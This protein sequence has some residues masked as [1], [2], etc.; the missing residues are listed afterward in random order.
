[1]W[2]PPLSAR[3]DGES[4]GQMAAL[5]SGLMYPAAP[6]LGMPLADVRDV[7]AAHC[8]ALSA[9]A[10]GRRYLLGEP[11]YPLLLAARV[12]RRTYPGRFWLPL[13][14]APRW[15]TLLI[16]PALG[17]PRALTRA[18]WGKKPR[19]DTTPARQ[20][21]GLKTPIPLEQTVVDMA[22]ALLE[23]GIVGG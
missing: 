20:D 8:A 21:L 15:L 17:L 10:P 6:P 14:A 19:L 7:A 18:M 2:G 9:G 13:T 12:L 5:M 3:A 16:G 4:I 22:A 23:L 11:C 1:V